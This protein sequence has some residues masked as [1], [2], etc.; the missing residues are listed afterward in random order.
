MAMEVDGDGVDGILQ[1]LLAP[2]SPQSM[3]NYYAELSKQGAGAGL[4]VRRMDGD[5]GKGVFANE[6][7]EAEELVL[8]EPP[9]VGA[10]HSRNKR[11]AIVCSNCFR[12]VGSIELQLARRLLLDD[13]S[14]SEADDN[15]N[16]DDMD[17]D[18][19]STTSMNDEDQDEMEPEDT[20]DIDDDCGCSGES[21][22]KKKALPS[23]A[24][25]ALESGALELPYS[26]RFP[27]PDVVPCKGGCSDDVYCS[28]K[29]AEAAWTNHH[30]LLCTGPSS[31]C[32]NIDALVSFKEFTNETNDI[33]HIAAQVIAA[34]VLR[35]RKLEGS[36]KCKHESALLKAWEPF[37]MGFKLLWWETVA[38][39]PDVDPA[40]ER[41]FRDQMKD[42]AAQSLTLLKKAIYEDKYD[43]L[44]SLDVYGRIIGMFELNNLDLVVASPVEDYFLYIDDLPPAAKAEAEAYTKPFLEALGDDYAAY[45]EGSAFYTLQ[46][47]MNHSCRP[48]ARA[49]KR[50]EDRDGHAVLLALRPI[51]K[52]EE[53]TISYID[54]DASLEERRAALADYAFLCRCSRCLEES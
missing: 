19:E 29:C 37:A 2:P 21:K 24:R 7:F 8:R 6:D 51:K 12:Y 38:L 5:T 31:R 33:F 22:K 32:K 23:D 9:L 42:I 18:G 44:F 17:A 26:D 20:N 53:V 47:C 45:C 30:S 16:H 52:G 54:E 50:D 13:G 3:Q 46:S 28:D 11:D 40:D 14:L 49:F 41:Q 36:I 48:N 34:T 10:Q 4:Q 25:S 15:A 35:A 27:L 39:P 43:P 1:K